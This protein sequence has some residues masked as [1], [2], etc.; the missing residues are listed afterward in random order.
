MEGHV[1]QGNAIA[2]AYRQKR[3]GSGRHP[4]AERVRLSRQALADALGASLQQVQSFE[5][6]AV[7]P[8]ASMLTRAAKVFDVPVRWFFHDDGQAGGWRPD[9]TSRPAGQ[10]D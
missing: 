6:G 5:T 2:A 10:P 8:S 1:V 3:S 4:A 9:G 7:R